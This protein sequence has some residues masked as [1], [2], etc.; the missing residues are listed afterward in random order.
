[1]D[2]KYRIIYNKEKCIGFGGC[3]A[4]SNL[5]DM[6]KAGKADL[7][8]GKKNSEGFY[9]LEI[10]EEDLAKNKDAAEICPVDVIWIIDIKTGE[11]VV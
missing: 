10:S 2:K 9:E 7:L 3:A 6:N 11:K 4:A 8:R 1:M 5:F